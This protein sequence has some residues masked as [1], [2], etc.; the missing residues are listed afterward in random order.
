MNNYK[1]RRNFR[2][3][4]NSRFNNKKNRSDPRRDGIDGTPLIIENEKYV[5]LAY[6][7]NNIN[8]NNAGSKYMYYRFR[9]NSVYD[10]DPL[11]G[12]GAIS[13]FSEYT[14]FYRRY[15]VTDIKV[16]WIVTNLESFPISLVMIPSTIDLAT[17]VTDAN[18][19]LDNMENQ[20]SV[21]R[22]VSAAGGM[23][24]AVIRKRYNLPAFHGL[25]KEYYDSM[26]Y[27][28]LGLANPPVMYFINFMAASTTN[29]VNGIDSTLQI[30]YKV[31]W[32]ERQNNL[33]RTFFR[34]LL[35]EE[36]DDTTETETSIS[37]VPN[38]TYSLAMG[39]SSNFVVPRNTPLHYE[40]RLIS[41]SLSHKELTK[42]T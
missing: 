17:T 2:N 27:S 12:S 40:G 9:A 15:L 16:T 3:R 30:Q 1:N 6:A 31:R 33:D 4:G 11:L 35:L 26:Q 28:G 5:T 42:K 32:Y 8:R 20:W 41:R 24:R 39:A 37:S 10:P 14:N 7:D 23:D 25:K 13:G 38:Q 18:D 34:K 19:V 29:F 21:F 22:K 36:D